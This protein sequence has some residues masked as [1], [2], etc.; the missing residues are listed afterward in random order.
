[1]MRTA[2]QG[3]CGAGD[4]ARRGRRHAVAGTVPEVPRPDS[5]GCVWATT[6][7]PVSYGIARELRHLADVGAVLG[8]F[9]GGPAFLGIAAP[10]RR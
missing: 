10:Q 3:R 5:E 9:T 2:R 8:L 4:R 6:L 7:M 1:M